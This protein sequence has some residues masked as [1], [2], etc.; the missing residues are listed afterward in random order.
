MNLIRIIYLTT[1]LFFSCTEPTLISDK[2]CK[3]KIG[4][5]AIVDECGV[6][7]GPGKTGCDNECG[8]T[9]QLDCT[10]VC[11]G[12]VQNDCKGECGGMAH[13]EYYCQ[14]SNIPGIALDLSTRTL[15]CLDENL[16]GNCSPNT[17]S[18]F[19]VDCEIDEMYK[20]S[21]IN[22]QGLLPICYESEEFCDQYTEGD[23]KW[24]DDGDCDF[25]DTNCEE[26][27]FDGG[28]CN[29]IDCNGLHFSEELCILVF[30]QGCTEGDSIALGDGFCDDGNDEELPVNFNCEKWGFDGA[31]C[32]C[33]D[34]NNSE[35]DCWDKTISENYI[36]LGEIRGGDCS[37]SYY[38]IKSSG[39]IT[40]KVFS[41][42]IFNNK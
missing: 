42:I 9:K 14:E 3:E 18:C 32:I 4:G 5:E 41:K 15:T 21:V 2:D 30:E 8:S 1:I 20:N 19:F 31:E 17:N 39:D 23:Y 27:N 12:N 13:F 37:D 25:L 6:C 36:C 38:R 33:K 10:G 11:D 40:H 24:I 7:N 35:Y 22:C 16:M 34:E 28:D 26:F 29:L